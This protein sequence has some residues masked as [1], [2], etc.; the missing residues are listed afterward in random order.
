MS[1]VCNLVSHK[2][3][4]VLAWKMKKNGQNQQWL[5]HVQLYIRSHM[6]KKQIKCA[7]I[8]EHVNVAVLFII[9]QQT[10]RK[11]LCQLILMPTE[12]SKLME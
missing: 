6:L 5:Y 1:N 9:H 3:E 8:I 12:L 10:Q 4:R 7:L 11:H 2:S